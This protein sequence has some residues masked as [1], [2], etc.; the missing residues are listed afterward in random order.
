MMYVVSKGDI[1]LFSYDNDDNAKS[2]NLVGIFGRF[3]AL[4][5]A[6]VLTHAS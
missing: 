2:G 4:I 5:G 3:G 6:G 1:P